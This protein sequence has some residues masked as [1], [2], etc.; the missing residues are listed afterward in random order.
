MTKEKL[1]ELLLKYIRSSNYM[2]ASDGCPEFLIPTWICSNR[3]R[4]YT[5]NLTKP[6]GIREISAKTITVTLT[7]DNIATKTIQNIPI[8]T[9]NLASGLKVQAIG[10]ENR[11]VEV[12]INGSSSI[13]KEWKTS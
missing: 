10:E 7:I 2:T 3:N 5:I 8:D 4:N 6:V 12:I 13:I 9:V 11:S 1:H